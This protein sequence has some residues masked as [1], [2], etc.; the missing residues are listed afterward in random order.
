[1]WYGAYRKSTFMLRCDLCGKTEEVVAWTRVPVGEGQG[2]GYA[3][4]M[5]FHDVASQIKENIRYEVGNITKFGWRP[6][7]ENTL[8]C[9]D[10][11]MA[12]RRLRE[13]VNS[14]QTDTIDDLWGF[15][16]ELIDGIKESRDA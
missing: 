2:M 12:R 10:K 11:C 7:S 8:V 1:M 9:S 15:M 16:N 14:Y 4:P 13:L 6:G 3:V 5:T